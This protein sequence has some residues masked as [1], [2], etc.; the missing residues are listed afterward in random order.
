MKTRNRL[1]SKAKVFG[2]RSL[3]LESKNNYWLQIKKR[4]L[5]VLT[6]LDQSCCDRN[7]SWQI[8]CYKSICRTPFF[9]FPSKLTQFA[10]CYR[11]IKSWLGLKKNMLDCPF[12]RFFAWVGRLGF[13][14]LERP[15]LHK[16]F[17][18]NQVVKQ[19]SSLQ[20]LFLR[21]YFG[22]ILQKQFPRVISF[23]VFFAR[24]INERYHICA[25]LATAPSVVQ[26]SVQLV[27]CESMTSDKQACGLIR[28]T[29]SP[30]PCVWG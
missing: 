12:T 14:F 7:Y 15:K 16:H 17:K 26:W 28:D 4:R 1:V 24:S 9:I 19:A 27:P 30:Y 13:F 10:Q 8:D 18:N 5:L 2:A 29:G 23:T 3:S 22:N 11:H 20:S 25:L 6:E 21:L